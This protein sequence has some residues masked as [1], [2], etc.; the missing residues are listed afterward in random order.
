MPPFDDERVAILVALALAEDIGAGDR[1]SEALLPPGVRARGRVRAKQPL[2]VCGLPLLELVFGR[3]GDVAIALEA[4]EGERVEPGRVLATIDGDARVLLAGERVALNLLQ[5]LCGIATLTRAYVDRVA[6]TPL[7][8]RD[9]RK[10]LP[11]MRLLAKYAVRTGGGVNHRLGLDDAILIKD[12]HLALRGGD[13]R[14]AVRVAR[15]A[16]PGL[17][18]EVECKTLLEVAEAVAAAPDLILLDN[19]KPTDVESA[20][21]T[22]GGRVPLEV[23]GG[24]TLEQ[25]PEIARAGVQLVAIGAL[26]HSAPAADLNLKIEPLS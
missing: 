15:Q 5:H 26:T 4:R 16:A 23:S 11:G 10:T 25:L 17:P 21:R 20:V 14:E 12:N 7:V 1:T 18:V 8:V 6:G 3:L 2:V 22:V 19:M 24:V 13:V 9:T